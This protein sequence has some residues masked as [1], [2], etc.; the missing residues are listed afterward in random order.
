MSKNK[1]EG[2]VYHIED[3][4]RDQWNELVY[5]EREEFTV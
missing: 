2:W 3:K 4:Y 1:N 5:Y